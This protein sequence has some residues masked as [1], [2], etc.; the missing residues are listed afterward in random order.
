MLSS[1]IAT[2]FFNSFSMYQ[3]TVLHCHSAEQVKNRFGDSSKANPDK[4]GDNKR[5]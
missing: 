3:G 2:E 1:R 4:Q 5:G